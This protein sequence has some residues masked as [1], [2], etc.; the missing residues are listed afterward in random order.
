MFEVDLLDEHVRD[1]RYRG[2]DNGY[3]AI[4][5]REH[6]ITYGGDK[7]MGNVFS[8]KVSTKDER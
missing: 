8:G 3:G 2:S 4:E 5:G 1:R 7:I 6:S